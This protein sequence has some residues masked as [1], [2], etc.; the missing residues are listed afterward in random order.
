MEGLKRTAISVAASVSGMQ[1][2]SFA[3]GLPGLPVSLLL[4]VDAVNV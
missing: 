2:I 3:V 4:V 1:I